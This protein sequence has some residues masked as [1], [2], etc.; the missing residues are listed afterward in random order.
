MNHETY[1]EKRRQNPEYV[2][3]EQQLKPLLDL[4]NDI[5]RLRTERGW[6]QKEL[7]RR[8][9]TQQA[10]ISDL[11]DGLTDPPPGVSAEAQ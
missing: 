9:G 6:T 1:L 2:R 11:E 8:V 10:D 5:I 7:A 4:A 3:I